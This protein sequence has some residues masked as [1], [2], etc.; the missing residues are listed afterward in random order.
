[1]IATTRC[2]LVYLGRAGAPL[3][4]VFA[5]LAVLRRFPPA[6]CSFYPQCPIHRYLH[7]LCPGC[8]TTRALAALLRGDIVHALHCNALTTLLM[9]FLLLYLVAAYRRFLASTLTRW[10]QPPPAALYATL[11]ASVVFTIARNL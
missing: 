10:P 6:E 5:T 4:V 1:M 3:V 8:G 9:P 7:L 11:A 2:R